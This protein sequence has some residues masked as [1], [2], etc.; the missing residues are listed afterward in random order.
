MKRGRKFRQAQLV[1]ATFNSH[2]LINEPGGSNSAHAVAFNLDNFAGAD[3]Y[4]VLYDMFRIKKIKYRLMTR[5]TINNITPDTVGGYIIHAL[6]YDDNMA[7]SDIAEARN[8]WSSKTCNWVG[9]FSR[10]FTPHCLNALK[11]ATGSATYVDSPRAS[12]WI[13]TSAGATAHY[14]VKWI[15]ALG[16][17]STKLYPID[18]FVTLYVQF[19]HRT[20]KSS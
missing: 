19:R 20:G 15:S 12:P 6:D 9:G 11:L 10:Y 1:N 17:V 16:G 4:K 13:S 5:A 7:W 14:G 8:A 3:K 2:L 18:E